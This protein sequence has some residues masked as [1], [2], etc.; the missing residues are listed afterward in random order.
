MM[1][2]M[3]DSAAR[4][5]PLA[6]VLLALLL[7]EPMHAY[8]MQRLI[9]ER[10]K[11]SVVNVARTNSVYQSLDRLS[12]DGLI[13]VRDTLRAPGRPDR[14]VY[15]IT[16]RGRA[17]LQRWLDSMLSTPAREFPEFPAALATISATTPA[18]AIHQ[19]RRRADA[20]ADL[21]AA[22]EA[23]LAAD[24]ETVPRL[25]LIEDEYR[26]TIHR[27]ELRWIRAIIDDI[28]SAR[29]TWSQEWLRSLAQ[30]PPA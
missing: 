1:K 5:S 10:S 14:T 3:T 27:T 18:N 4:S 16:E 25:F 26:L 22:A 13:R 9:K 11:D 24:A 17:T 23:E 30:S 12:R 7:E 8:R 15:E 28:E 6:T 19:L 21:V 2:G 29:L 20:L